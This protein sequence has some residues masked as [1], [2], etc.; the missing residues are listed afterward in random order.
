MGNIEQAIKCF[1]QAVCEEMT[2]YS[3]KL[4]LS[5]FQNAIEIICKSEKN[6][7]RL[8]ITGIGKPHHI[9]SYMAS[10][11]SSTGTPCYLLDGTEATH[12][13]SGQVVPGDVVICVSY[14]GNVPELIKTVKTL[15][16]NGAKIIA[17]T[18]FN[19][20]WIAKK[21]DVHLNCHVE[22][23]GDFLGRPPRISMLATLY[24]LMELSVILQEEKGINLEKYIK[25]HP[26]GELGKI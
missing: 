12:G 20:S 18:G 14:Y 8:H 6:G 22:K 25:Y 4:D 9:S 15:K 7:N 11:F 5:Y 2:R 23:E 13:S 24:T 3:N 17:V 21:A 19:D 10:L 1:N 26:S 16:K